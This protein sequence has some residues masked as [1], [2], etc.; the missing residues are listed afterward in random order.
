MID[1]IRALYAQMPERL[2]RARREW[3]RPLT[4][5][6]K[7]LVAHVH[8]WKAQVWAV[9]SW[10]CPTRIFSLRVSGRFHS[11]RARARRSGIDV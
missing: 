11:R 3:N 7:V 9:Q 5:A 1:A 8:D 10:T 4:L 2:A 6:A